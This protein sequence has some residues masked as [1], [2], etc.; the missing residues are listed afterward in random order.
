V[1]LDIEKKQSFATVAPDE[2][3]IGPVFFV[4]IYAI[5][6]RVDYSFIRACAH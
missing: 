2:A 5:H 1:K 4:A 6:A 3:M